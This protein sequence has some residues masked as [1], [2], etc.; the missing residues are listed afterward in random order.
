MPISISLPPASINGKPI[1]F[2]IRSWKGD[3]PVE[4]IAEGSGT[5]HV[6]ESTESGKYDALIA[7]EVYSD[8]VV[9]KWTFTEVPLDQRAA[10]C[11]RLEGDGT[12][13]CVDDRLPS[14]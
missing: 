14:W 10:D 13:S 7:V 6:N 3:P 2:R 8:E 1:A 4:G 5:L 11:L 9:S 12:L